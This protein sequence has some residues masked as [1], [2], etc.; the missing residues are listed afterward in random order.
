MRR[1]KDDWVNATQILKLCNF[2]KAKRTKILE[3]CVQ[4]GRHEKVQGGYGRFQGTWIPLEDARNL[5]G[6]FQISP[7]LVPI[8]YIDV[9]DPNLVILKKLKPSAPNAPRNTTPIKRKLLKKPLETLKKQRLVD[10]PPLAVFVPDYMNTMGGAMPMHHVPMPHLPQSAIPEYGHLGAPG[11]AGPAYSRP[12]DYHVQA[13]PGYGAG[14]TLDAKQHPA[15]M[16]APGQRHVLYQA[17]LNSGLLHDSNET[18]WSRE[19]PARESDTSVSSA[20]A[21]T[22]ALAYHEASPAAQM[23]RYFSEDNVPI[24]YFIYH[25]TP[26]FNINDAIDDEG[27]STLHWAASIGNLDLVLLVLAKGANPLVVSN[28]GMNPLSKCISFN[29]C[30]DLGNFSGVLNALEACLIHTDING[31]TPLHYLCQFAKV[32][33]KLASLLHYN[34]LMFRKITAIAGHG[35]ATGLNL[36][37]NVL[38]HQDINGDTCLHLAAR[39]ACPEIFRYFLKH[40]ARDDLQNSAQETPKE[41][42]FRAIPNAYDYDPGTV[43]SIFDAPLSGPLSAKKLHLSNAALGTPTQPRHSFNATPDTQRTTVQQDDD[44]EDVVCDRVSKEHLRSLM[45]DGAAHDE[46]KENIFLDEGKKIPYGVVSTSRVTKAL[47]NYRAA[48]ELSALLQS[49]VKDYVARPPQLDRAGHVVEERGSGAEADA[50]GTTS[51]A[52]LQPVLPV[53]DLAS[54]LHGMVNSLTDSCRQQL[55]G[56]AREQQRL[57]E[58][59]VR[60]RK[61]RR[62][63]SQRV[64]ALMIKNGLEAVDT[65]EAAIEAVQRS[66][67]TYLEVL[68][69]SERQLE[70]LMAKYQAKELCGMVERQ[71]G[72]ESAQNTAEPLDTTQDRYELAMGV[73][74]AQVRREKLVRGLLVSMKKYAIDSRM[75]KYRK[76]ISVS[77]GLRME[78]IDSLING[79]EESLMESA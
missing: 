17:E 36:L 40:G 60:T 58:C 28:Y 53:R 70:M 67:D 20:D 44:D 16:D 12:Y 11:P 79:I 5:A 30:F 4:M 1:C 6:E 2:P 13:G 52:A 25:P 38:N 50:S 46:N 14:Q 68:A 24:P 10:L 37:R 77:C 75:N 34:E 41:L 7:D 51:G 76:L 56:L 22:S 29:N 54:M 23:L 73:A 39:A 21:K 31:R 43:P 47:P 78:D 72:A 42:M 59:L 69:R 62:G 63:L 9:H 57:E 32:R 15:P 55:D 71:Q 66:S 74:R 3:K 65:L 19:E 35:S 33:S 26:E 18:T 8:L 48:S 27:H 64:R 49:P 61:E 45:G